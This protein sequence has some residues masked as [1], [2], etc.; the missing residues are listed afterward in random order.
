[1]EYAFI[2]I[3]TGKKDEATISSCRPCSTDPWDDCTASRLKH[4]LYYMHLLA[5]L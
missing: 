5:E 4:H 1:M 2:S 3:D